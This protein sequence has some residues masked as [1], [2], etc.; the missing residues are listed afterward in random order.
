MTPQSELELA[1]L[2]LQKNQKMMEDQ[3]TNMEGRMTNVEAMLR[4]LLR[5]EFGQEWEEPQHSNSEER[6]EPCDE[7]PL[8]FESNGDLKDESQ[9]EMV[10]SEV[11][12]QES[13]LL[14]EVQADE[15]IEDH[16]HIDSVAGSEYD[17][18]NNA[19]EVVG[20]WEFKQ[21]WQ[22]ISNI[23]KQKLSALDGGERFLPIVEGKQVS[24][25]VV[26]T[27]IQETYAK[28]GCVYVA[29]VVFDDLSKRDIEMWTARHCDCINIG[30]NV[31]TDKLKEVNWGTLFSGLSDKAYVRNTKKGVVLTIVLFPR[32]KVQVEPLVWTS[33]ISPE[34]IIDKFVMHVNY[35]YPSFVSSCSSL[36][37]ILWL[38][39]GIGSRNAQV[40]R[41]V[42]FY[43]TMIY[44]FDPGVCWNDFSL[45][46]CGELIMAIM[47]GI[48]VGLV[49]ILIPNVWGYEYSNEEVGRYVANMRPKLWAWYGQYKSCVAPVIL[50]FHIESSILQTY[51]A[52]VAILTG[53][54]IVAKSLRYLGNSIDLATVIFDLEKELKWKDIIE[55]ELS[56]LASTPMVFDPGGILINTKDLMTVLVAASVRM[57]KELAKR[58]TKK[59]SSWI[60]KVIGVF[61]LDSRFQDHFCELNHISW[62]LK[63]MGTKNWEEKLQEATLTIF[64]RIRDNNEAFI[65]SSGMMLWFLTDAKSETFN[66]LRKGKYDSVL[67]P[68]NPD[69]S[70]VGGTKQASCATDKSAHDLNLEDKV[71]FVGVD[72]D[73]NRP[74][75]RAEAQHSSPLSSSDEVYVT[76]MERC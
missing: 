63:S 27:F 51:G 43:R 38:A 28:F 53:E 13:L 60:A 56:E 65:L 12:T 68:S 9:F 17:G 36:A 16:S 39:Q 52:N 73:M 14:N 59:L 44:P 47:E 7:F 1:V 8:D 64:I 41:N 10:A 57:R 6:L 67:S 74:I 25:S 45:I 71:D 26:Q 11:A 55:Y 23:T 21:E 58:S 19:T 61:L 33:K 49:I 5:D 42:N 66:S 31:L 54:F 18:H 48:L 34:L 20:F 69:L 15:V 76:L 75:T 46:V 4:Q 37:E 70:T 24:S 32:L 62:V 35:E 3:M 50:G 72:I 30:R 2:E 22:E 29:H 40:A